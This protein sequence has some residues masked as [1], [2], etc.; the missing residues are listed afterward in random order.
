M[1][2]VGTAQRLADD[3]LFPAALTTDATDTLPIELLDALADAGLYGLTG[4]ASAGGAEADFPS[5]CAVVEAL[6]CRVHL[7]TGKVA[8]RILTRMQRISKAL[9]TDIAIDGDIGII[10]VRPDSRSLPEG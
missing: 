4:P 1:H 3:E 8:Q 5:V 2:I 9:G 6:A 10:R 7:S